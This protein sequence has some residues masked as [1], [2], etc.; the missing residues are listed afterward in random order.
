MRLLIAIVNYRCAGLT[1]GCLR[2]LAPEVARA[3]AAVVVV[4]NDSRDGSAQ[5][6]ADA[7]EAAGWDWA[8]LVAA[9]RNGGFA[10]GN[11]LAIRT[12]QQQAPLPEFVLLLN[13]DCEVRPG[14]LDALLGFLDAHPR[15]GIAGSRLEDADGTP[16]H[17]RFRFSRPVGE[18]VS[19]AHL[20]LLGRIFPY[21]EYT[22]ALTDEPHEIDWV[23][24]A[25]MILRREVLEQ[26]GPM[27]E[28]YFLYFEEQDY[29]LRA[30]RAGWQVW[31]VPQS[32][33]VHHVSGSTGN[34]PRQGRSPRR[35]RYWFESRHRFFTKSY[36]RLQLW[37]ANLAWIAAHLFASAR[38][39]AARR[40]NT[41]PP[42]LLRDFVRHAM[43]ARRP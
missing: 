31:Y 11:N 40:P 17:S 12:W 26:V 21:G 18:L 16:Q 35:P 43:F 2:S 23:S 7:I 5:R 36:G 41:D 10:F 8:R 38:R 24:G 15:A 4:D 6:I 20:G 37:L 22:P 30:R 39:V 27:D 25:A 3:G 9:D 19:N 28:G 13:P 32:R 34:F 33:V 14:A 42:Y 1:I 29:Q